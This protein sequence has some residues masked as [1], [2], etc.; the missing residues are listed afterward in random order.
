MSLRR[1]ALKSAIACAVGAALI[2]PAAASAAGTTAVTGGVLTYADTGPGINTLSITFTSGYYVLTDPGGGTLGPGAGCVA[3]TKHQVKCAYAGVNSISVDLGSGNDS[4]TSSLA[5]TPTTVHGGP[6]NDTLTGGFAPESLFGDD[7]ADTID[8]GGGDDALDGGAGVDNLNGGAGLDTVTSRDGE[9]DTVACGSE[10]DYVVSDPIDGVA[11]DC[12]NVDDGSGA[13]APAPPPPADGTP[14]PAPVE[15]GTPVG[16]VPPGGAAGTL[17]DP[18]KVAIAQTAATATAGGLVGI[19][20]GCPAGAAAA[21]S[22]SMTLVLP[23]AAA[24]KASGDVAAARRRKIVKRRISRARRFQVAA[25]K[26]KNVNVRLTSA[27]KKMLCRRRK[28]SVQVVVSL[29]QQGG[30]AVT[31]THK[32][33]LHAARRRAPNR[34]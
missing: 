20:V 24:G 22:G 34:C 28:L 9:A 18:P 5:V 15:P 21:C 8:G 3:G 32:I 31:S 27:A 11:A 30:K 4:F 2:V 13:A 12:E 6:G 33:T 10:T 1:G 17:T 7:G 26:K 23:V 25:G 14:G 19:A 16:T 29:K